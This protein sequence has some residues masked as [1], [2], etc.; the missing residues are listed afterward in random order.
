MLFTLGFKP[1]TSGEVGQEYIWA[2]DVQNNLL[3]IFLP[4]PTFFIASMIAYLIS[5]YFDVW[6][7]KTIADLT[8]NRFLWLRNNSENPIPLP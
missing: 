5:Q 8:N 7:Y 4:L 2:L 3:S 6:F 1:L